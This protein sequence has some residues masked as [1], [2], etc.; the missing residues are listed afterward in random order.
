MY[1]ISLF[2]FFST[3]LTALGSLSP[4]DPL[5]NTYNQGFFNPNMT[6]ETS[7]FDLLYLDASG[8]TSLLETY[9]AY[10]LENI[11]E[12]KG[13]FCDYPDTAD[14]R[15]VLYQSSIDEL[16][17]MKKA[18][19]SKGLNLGTGFTGNTFA[20]SIY[21]NKCTET[22]DY[23]IFAKECEPYVL[24]HNDWLPYNRDTIAMQELIK[25]GLKLFLK[26]KSNF[27]KLRYAYQVIRLAH[28][29]KNYPQVL[30]LCDYLFPKMDKINSVVWYWIYGHQAGALRALGRN[31]ASAQL[32]A[33]VFLNCRSKRASALRSL[34]ITTDEEWQKAIA[35]CQSDRERT[36]LFA[37]RASSIHAKSLEDMASIYDLDPASEFLPLLLI[38]ETSRMEKVFLTNS[39]KV[40]KSQ[41]SKGQTANSKGQD[42]VQLIGF[43]NKALKE[44]EVIHV[45]IWRTC[46]AYLHILAGNWY[47]ANMALENAKPYGKT[48][49]IIKEQLLV[50]EMALR[51]FGFQDITNEVAADSIASIRKSDLFF[52]YPQFSEI[53]DEKLAFL[54]KNAGNNG[55]SFLALHSVQQLAMNPDLQLLDDLIAI[56][57]KEKLNKLELSLVAK[58]SGETVL[59]DLLDIK[60]TYLLGQG[61]VEAALATLQQIPNVSKPKEQYNPFRDRLRDCNDCNVADSILLTKQELV[62]KILD[63]EFQA[64]ASLDEGAVYYYQLGLAYYNLSFFG[65]SHQAADF[66][67][68]G[69]NWTRINK[70]PVFPVRNSDINNRENLDISKAMANFEKARQMAKDPELAA[71]AAFWGAKCELAKFYLSKDNLYKP[72]NKYI[73]K[74]PE[75]YRNYY[76]ILKQR[77]SN[78]AFYQLAIKECKFFDAYVN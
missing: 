44:N 8:M 10:D 1:K 46:L 66:Y 26:N 40:Q 69:F 72:G 27:L 60:A 63:L 56:C 62:Q 53:L 65:Q 43:C 21:V 42:L 64:K 9:T 36:A 71:R 47:E 17:W 7:P 76:G 49:E 3:L 6:K 20:E 51:I 75:T 61:E 4:C 28:Y 73:P 31:A 5:S 14:I 52:E 19:G 18:I 29:K 57:R 54:Y 16:D 22:V 50:F 41:S 39:T 11:L 30:L 68:S 23:L 15:Y 37:M 38:K 67:R 13:R 32:Y 55:M 58:S 70:G 2:I 45:E 12:W 48:N 77:Y 35:A 78:T 25:K 34:R 59:N 74:I 33:S 24:G